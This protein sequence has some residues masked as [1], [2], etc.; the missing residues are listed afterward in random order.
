MTEPSDAARAD[1]VALAVEHGLDD[2]ADLL[3]QVEDDGARAYLAERLAEAALPPRRPTRGQ[4]RSTIGPPQ[5]PTSAFV[6]AMTEA[7]G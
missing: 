6:E 1:A 4:G 3:A 2:A 5:S 7:L